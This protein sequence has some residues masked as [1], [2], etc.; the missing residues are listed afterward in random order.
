MHIWVIL[1]KAQK[2]AKQNIKLNKIRFIFQD[3]LIEKIS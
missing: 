1:Q 2:Q 3:I